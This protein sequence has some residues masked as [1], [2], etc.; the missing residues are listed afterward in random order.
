MSP[1]SW[2][3]SVHHD[4]SPRYVSTQSGN[5]GTA[6]QLRLRA[7]LAA[8]IRAVFLRTCP[9]GEQAM[10]PLQRRA[11]D[12]ACQWW[13]GAVTL[14]TPRTNYRFL[15]STSDGV[16]TLNAAGILRHTPGDHDDFV[17]LADYAAPDWVRE[18]V[19]YQIFPDRFCDGEPASN[20]RTGEY[21]VHRHATVAREWGAEPAR[22]GSGGA[23]SAEFFG[24]DLPG[25]TQRL[26]YL[27]DLGVT[28]LYLTPVFVSPSNHKYDVEDFD[29]VDPHFGGDAALVA[30]RQALDARGMRLM[31]D[32]VPNHC[33]NTHPW[34]LAAQADSQA[35]TA[36]FFSFGA[37]YPH[38]YATWLNVR[39]LAKLNYRSQRL[40][41][42]MYAG[43]DAIMRRWLRPPY[44]ID[45]W[46]MD[47][48]NMLG[49][50]GT[51][52]L[53]HAVIQGIRAAVKAEAPET[54]LLGENFFDGTPQ[55]QGDELDATMNYQG[56]MFPVMRWLAPAD[57]ELLEGRP[58]ADPVPLPTAAVAAQWHA[59]LAAIPW[60]VA[61]QQ[62]NLLGSHDTPRALTALGG[63]SNRLRV[64]AALLF[65]FPGV[66]C[67][68][69]GDEV[70]LS[71]GP[72][73]ACR[74]CMPWEPTAW[75]TDLRAW[76][77]QLIDLRRH[78]SALQSGGFQLLLAAEHTLAF[79]REA[80]GEHLIIVAKRAPD[81][82]TTLPV[83]PASL[84][85]GTRL[86]E[87]ITNHA[88]TVAGGLLPLLPP[89]AGADI[90]I[91]R[92]LLDE[93]DCA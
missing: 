12:A 16:W 59:N 65:T 91:W 55:L 3:A 70:G 21:T 34:F 77:M 29:H 61:L 71:G 27:N 81:D 11:D 1:P 73:P 45:G 43:S 84:P 52:Q 86:D 90:Q 33:S 22:H 88:S 68:F 54:Y 53:G 92:V 30:L 82:I 51:T 57:P 4:G 35:P 85:D 42:V 87:I 93:A 7:G 75:D 14:L 6:I 72:A 47:V 63:D 23:G 49:R 10:T 17:L 13:E 66:P 2:T 58:Y 44:R 74:V 41:E 31:L 9:D 24:G 67:I 69:Y 46:R 76:Y 25:I 20:V 28:A 32:I 62:F 78:S 37:D 19:F 18:A 83:A 89:R 40:R 5:I 15:L 8:P 38:G 79:A 26:G 60:V 80:P 36:E 56:F 64:A 48:A 39:S 50:Q